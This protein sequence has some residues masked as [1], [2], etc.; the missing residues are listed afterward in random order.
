MCVV[1]VLCSA[2]CTSAIDLSCVASKEVEDVL[3]MFC[4]S[5]VKHYV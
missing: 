3:V 4:D 1:F 5:C 2:R